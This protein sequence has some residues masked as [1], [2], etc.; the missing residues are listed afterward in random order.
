MSDLKSLFAARAEPDA[1]HNVKLGLGAFKATSFGQ[2]EHA[3]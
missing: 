3:P 2:S 1:R